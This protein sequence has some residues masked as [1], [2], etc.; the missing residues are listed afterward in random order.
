MAIIWTTEDTFK[1]LG[2][3]IFVS[4]FV[5]ALRALLTAE[6]KFKAKEAKAKSS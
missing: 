4:F 1:A 3:L 6:A 2:L 5:F